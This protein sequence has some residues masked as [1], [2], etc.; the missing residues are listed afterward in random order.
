[1]QQQHQQ[2]IKAFQRTISELKNAQLKQLKM[3]IDNEKKQRGLVQKQF[4]QKTKTE[5][6]RF[7]QEARQLKDKYKT[8]LEQ[9]R[10]LYS[11]QNERLA[12][13]M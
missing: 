3:I 12:S 7:D 11:A 6:R 1:M 9:T 10:Q 5:K 4:E 8:Q 2:D 13:E